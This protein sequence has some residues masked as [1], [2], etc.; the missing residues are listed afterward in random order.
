MKYR[1]DQY[2]QKAVEYGLKNPYSIIA[3]NM[4]MGKSLCALDI[5]LKTGRQP[6]LIV[7]PGYLILNWKLEIEKFMPDDVIGSYFS[8][9]DF[10]HYPFDSDIVV[11][12]Y[13]MVKKA[14][15]LFEWAKIVIA[16]EPNLLKSMKA[17]RT[18]FFH[19]CIFE[20]SIKRLHLLTGT[21][22]KNRVEEY[23]S[24]IALCNYNPKILDSRFFN[25]FPDSVT[26]ADYFSFRREYDIFVNGRRHQVIKWEGSRREDELKD[27]LSGIYI[28]LVNNAEKPLLFK[29]I[30]VSEVNQ[31]ELLA[32]FEAFAAD[33]EDVKPEIK[34]EAALKTAPLT[35]KYCRD[36]LEEVGQL[37]IYSDH[38]EPIRKIAES[39]GVRPI[40]AS[41]SPKI[42]AELAADFQAGKTKV[43]CATIG[44]FSTGVTLTA[45]NHLVLNDPAWTPGD[46]EQVYYRINR[47]GQTRQCVIH[48]M[49]GSPQAKYIYDVLEKKKQTIAKVT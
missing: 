32:A 6:M 20:N 26:F 47:I 45:A 12:S 2:Q 19:R 18:E 34:V 16:D 48:R 44:S 25:K 39:F 29:D 11:I 5:W 22:V 38:V 49:L 33:N 17:Q 41:T 42:R 28:R 43:I 8:K 21:P 24:L 9:G 3:L 10:L 35:A 30:H 7:C 4:G 46:L 1:L 31:P 15:Y 13:E 27:L 36:L 14:E 23:Y 37:A 40:T